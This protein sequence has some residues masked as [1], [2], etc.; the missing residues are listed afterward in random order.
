[1]RLGQSQTGL[2]LYPTIVTPPPVPPPPAPGPFVPVDLSDPFNTAMTQYRSQSGLIVQRPLSLYAPPPPPGFVKFNPGNWT[3]SD[4]VISAGGGLSS[5]QAEIDAMAAQPNIVGFMVLLTWGNLQQAANTYTFSN[6]DAIVAYIKSKGKRW[7][8]QV[9][10]GNFNWSGTTPTFSTSIIPS[11]ILGGNTA[12]FGQ[13]GYRVGGVTTIVPGQSGVWGGDGNG[14]TY[15][16][17]LWRP[18]VMAEWIKLAQAVAAKYDS[19]P[20]FEGYYQGEDSFYQGTGSTNNSDYNDITQLNNWKNYLT[21]CC[22]AFPTSN[23]WFSETFMQ[24]QQQSISLTNFITDGV[25]TNHPPVLA[26]TDALG[27]VQRQGSGSALHS[28]GTK[29][30]AGQLGTLGDRRSSN[31]FVSEVQAP[32]IGFFV[33]IGS[34][35]EDI[36]AGLNYLRATHVF[37]AIVPNSIAV[38]TK[39]AKF[40]CTFTANV[41]GTSG[42][43]TAPWS[44]PSG[45]YDLVTNTGGTGTFTNGSTSVSFSTSQT[46]TSPT[47]IINFPLVPYNWSNGGTASASANGTSRSYTD[48]GL[49]SW[50]NTLTNFPA[51]NTNPYI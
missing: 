18:N 27:F 10:A 47:I 19:D 21:A 41:T 29:T 22:A 9:V 4:T 1:M 17:A 11:Y 45:V 30:Y 26:Q 6:L 16:A 40:P 13:A 33:N 2:S 34:P 38:T 14:K 36:L 39:P 46:Q 20:A 15:A 43:L 28:W 50:A 25:F 48:P 3:E 32:D 12:A 5:I 24:F 31:R 51:N 49:L 44:L 37:W 23:V 8:L 7:C 35:R 42:T